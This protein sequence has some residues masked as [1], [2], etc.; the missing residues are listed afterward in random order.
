MN[1]GGYIQKFST[2]PHFVVVVPLALKWR[3]VLFPICYEDLHL[4]WHLTDV[5]PWA[6]QVHLLAVGKV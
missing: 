2:A 3:A 4:L 6:I 5:V 1:A